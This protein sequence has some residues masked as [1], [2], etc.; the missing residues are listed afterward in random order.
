MLSHPGGGESAPCFIDTGFKYYD[1][2][3]IN[4]AHVAEVLYDYSQKV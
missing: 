3:N 2:S 1:A 4:D